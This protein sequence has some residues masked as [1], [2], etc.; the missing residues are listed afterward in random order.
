MGSSAR[1]VDFSGIASPP[2]EKVPVR[3]RKL[4]T[5]EIS[6]RAEDLFCDIF[7]FLQCFINE[8]CEL[9]EEFARHA[10]EKN[11]LINYFIYCSI[12]ST[13]THVIIQGIIISRYVDEDIFGLMIAFLCIICVFTLFNFCFTCPCSSVLNNSKGTL[14][15]Y[16]IS[17]CVYL[18]L[19]CD[20]ANFLRKNDYDYFVGSLILFFS[21]VNIHGIALG[22]TTVAALIYG[23][24]YCFCKLIFYLSL[25]C[26]CNTEEVKINYLTIYLYDP[27]KTEEKTCTI[28]LQEYEKL[29]RI[30]VC[31]T[32]LV[33]IFHED[34][35]ST[36]LS[37]NSTCPLC[38][39]GLPANFH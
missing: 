13:V 28:C 6:E 11:C 18:G 14:F 26:C 30:C 17:L 37:I 20:V 35:I 15:L 36:W 23:I 22:L 21:C 7:R 2:F 25:R 24:L 12:I 19:F 10:D 3:R 27:S 33:H 9:I 39:G 1:V 31:K 8:G 4:T 32:H 16:S 29:D 34:C 5:E 38:G